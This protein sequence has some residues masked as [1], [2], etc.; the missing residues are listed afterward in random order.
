VHD[1]ADLLRASIASAGNDHRLGANEAPPAIIS[2][3]IGNQLTQV[4]EDIEKKVKAGKMTSEEKTV[5]KL[6]IGKIPEI[7][8]DN[9]DRNRTSPFAFT[10]NKFEFRAVGASA[11]CAAAMTILNTIVADQLIQF[12]KEV[13]AQLK[14]GVDKDEA[15]F[16]ILRDY[17]TASKKIL[18]EGNGYSEEWVREAKKRGLSNIKNTPEALKVF[19]KKEYIELLERNGVMSK[20]EQHARYEVQLETYV[21]K[22]Q[23]ESRLVG[24]I[25]LENII[26]AAIKYQ[27]MLIENIKGMKEI[28]LLLWGEKV[29]QAK[30]KK[31]VLAGGGEVALKEVETI[32]SEENANG[33]VSAQVETIKK[34]S[35][36]VSA[37]RSKVYEM[38]EARK[39]ANTIE[40]M[41][42]RANAYCEYVKPWMDEIRYHADKLEFIVDDELWPLPKYREMLFTR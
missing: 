1:N 2:V 27:N 39:R 11:N 41:Q 4:L 28:Q 23:I 19:T 5:L 21:K 42:E 30:T 8:L 7:L 38:I 35:E 34:I 24:E 29:Q 37:I 14:E 17:I 32:S 31:A 33:L 16:K 26:P 6:G 15:I 40:D 18:F 9:T 36:H 25:A 10:G 22:L 3:F 12:K 13:D 20:R